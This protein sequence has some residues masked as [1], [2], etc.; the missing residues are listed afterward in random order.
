MKV[1][2]QRALTDRHTMGAPVMSGCSKRPRWADG[3]GLVP[4]RCYIS[5][6][7]SQGIPRH[8]LA[9]P[10][11]VSPWSFCLNPF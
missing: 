5:L 11:I 10:A 1:I 6:S 9:E 4:R 8:E 7:D 2:A 3:N